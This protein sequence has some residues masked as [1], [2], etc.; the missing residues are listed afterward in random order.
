MQSEAAKRIIDLKEVKDRIYWLEHK[1]KESKTVEIN[2]QN[3]ILNGE[4]QI[5]RAGQLLNGLKSEQ[6]KWSLLFDEF[7]QKY[8]NSIGDCLISAAFVSFLSPFP[9]ELRQLFC[10]KWFKITQDYGLPVDKN[11]VFHK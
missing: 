9:Q 3:Q 11:F 7:S 4:T 6:E 2:L 1:L 10:K 8:E 5:S